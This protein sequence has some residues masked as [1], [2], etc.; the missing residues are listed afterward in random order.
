MVS[1]PSYFSTLLFSYFIAVAMPGRRETESQKI[2]ISTLISDEFRYILS[3]L[4]ATTIILRI[5]LQKPAKFYG[6]R[7]KEKKIPRAS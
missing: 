1:Y 4:F 6:M 2:R 7:Q 5:H 3:G